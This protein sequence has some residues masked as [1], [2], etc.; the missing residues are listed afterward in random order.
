[1]TELE[2]KALMGDREAQRICTEQGIVLRCPFC[3]GQATV[4]TQKQDYGI[5]GTIVKCRWCLAS[6]YCLDERAHITE[7]GIRNVPVE[8]HRYIAIHRW[9]TRPAL[10][11]GRCGECRKSHPLDER[12]PIQWQ[13]LPECVWCTEYHTGKYKHD[14]CSEFEPKGDEENA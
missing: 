3:G 11:V 7:N 10:P 12:D 8:N 1:M 6:V 2:R 9:N 5:S 14:F 4:K 13:Y